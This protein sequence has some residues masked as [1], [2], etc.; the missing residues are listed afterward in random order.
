MPFTAEPGSVAQLFGLPT[1]GEVQLQRQAEERTRKVKMAAIQMALQNLPA[2]DPRRAD[3]E[4]RFDEFV[5]VPGIGSTIAPEPAAAASP[6]QFTLG[7]GQRRFRTGAEGEVEEIARGPERIQPQAGTAAQQ[8]MFGRGAQG[9]AMEAIVRARNKQRQGIPLTP[10]DRDVLAF[11]RQILNQAQTRSI[12]GG[13]MVRV[14]APGVPARFESVF[15]EVPEQLGTTPGGTPIER[16][17]TQ[18]QQG[19]IQVTEIMAP[20]KDDSFEKDFATVMDEA[21]AINKLLV[22]GREEFGGVTGLAG[23]LKA[24][25]GGVARQL[26]VPVSSRAKQLQRGLETIKAIALPY[27]LGEKGRSLS[28]ADRNRLDRIVGTLDALSDE[29]DIREAIVNVINIVERAGPQ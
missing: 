8:P 12:P 1:R 2:E 28:D 19:R 3:L 15:A 22:E 20:R 11:S 9:M 6:Q 14:E 27:V 18:V 7:P 25:F 5:G 16:A 23:T 10:E 29:Q 24:Q 13:G 26:G 17:T 4:S 21:E